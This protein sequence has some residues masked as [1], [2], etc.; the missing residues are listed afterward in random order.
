[1]SAPAAQCARGDSRIAPA[2][3]EQLMAL[4][5]AMTA[6]VPGSGRAR[7]ARRHPVSAPVAHQRPVEDTAPSLYA[8][9]IQLLCAPRPYRLFG[10]ADEAHARDCHRCCGTGQVQFDP[11]PS[12]EFG[13]QQYIHYQPQEAELPTPLAQW[14]D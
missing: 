8:R 9:T 12:A 5:G 3:R 2:K 14:I 13:S 1:M 6:E 11:Q 10:R 7:L 4:P